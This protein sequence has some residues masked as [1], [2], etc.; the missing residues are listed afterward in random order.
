[1]LTQFCK[2]RTLYH[3]CATVSKF[4]AAVPEVLAML[5]NVVKLELYSLK[6]DGTLRMALAHQLP[7]LQE[8]RVIRCTLPGI[9]RMAELV[10]FFPHLKKFKVGDVFVM[11]PEPGHTFPEVISR[12]SLEVIRFPSRL[13]LVD[14]SISN[15]LDW[16]VKESLH[17]HIRTLDIVLFRHKE[18]EIVR[19]LLRGVGPSLQDLSFSLDPENRGESK[20]ALLSILTF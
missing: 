12:P 13:F 11:P 18:A 14:D 9:A 16:L 6:I 10:C 8:I 19:N 3:I 4:L 15:F 17:T 7:L 5:P 2:A 20:C 1:M